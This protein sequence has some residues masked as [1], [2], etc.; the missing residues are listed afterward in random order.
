MTART[1]AGKLVSAFG[2]VD[3]MSVLYAPDVEWSLSAS[4]PF[5]RPMKGFD[6]VVAFNKSV[7]TDS[8]FPD[9]SVTILDEIGDERLSAVRFIYRARFRASGAMYE[10]E[11]TLFARGSGGGIREVFEA[12]DT[13]A[14]LDQLSGGKIG[15]TF[16]KAMGE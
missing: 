4:L 11:Y 9:C 10:N 6:A 5:P 16:A 3:A 1:P 15:D 14:V 8:Y 7:W 13:A 2:N 12:L